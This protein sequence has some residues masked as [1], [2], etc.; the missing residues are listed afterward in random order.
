MLNYE[1]GATSRFDVCVMRH[2]RAALEYW[3]LGGAIAM[4]HPDS[5]LGRPALALTATPLIYLCGDSHGRSP[6]TFLSRAR[7]GSRDFRFAGEGGEYFV[8]VGAAGA[9]GDTR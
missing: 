3:R 1:F 7:R 2:S 5:L 4:P 8:V 9:G 6:H